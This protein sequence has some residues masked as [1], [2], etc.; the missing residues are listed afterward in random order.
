MLTRLAIR[1]MLWGL[2]SIF[3]LALSHRLD[4]DGS[5]LFVTICLLAGVMI[6]VSGFLV[7]EWGHLIG[8]WASGARLYMPT[9]VRTIFL[10]DF[11]PAENSRR[12]FLSL[13][14]GGFIASTLMVLL[15][16]LVLSLDYLADQIALGLT[17]LGVL[18]TFVL[19]VPPAWRV[20]KGASPPGP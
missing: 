15:L 1:D 6:P 13:F 16:V 4:A 19:E 5:L 7:H 8:A 18:A 11:K 3:M 9:S 12:Q 14:C 17:L 10:F 2:A 20:W